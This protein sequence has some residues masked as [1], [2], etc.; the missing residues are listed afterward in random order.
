LHLKE[1]SYISSRRR[2]QVKKS[3]LAWPCTAESL[4][5]PRPEA[6]TQECLGADERVTDFSQLQKLPVTVVIPTLNEASQ[7]CEAVDAARWASEVVV[8]DGGSTDGTQDLARSAGARVLEVPRRTIAAQRNAG[9]VAAR[10]DW[11]LALDADERVTDD[12]RDELGAV[13]AAPQHAA[14]RIHFRN[15]YLG[16][17]LRHGSWGRDWHVRLFSH[18]R[19]FLERRVHE[20]L[21]P[22]D[23]VGSLSMELEHRPYRDL[24]HHFEK[25]IR[26]ARWGA[27]DL[28]ARGR[29]PSA[30]DVTGVPAWRFFREYVIFS[31]W[32]DGRPGLVVAALSACSALLK[33]AYLFALEWQTAGRPASF[34][35]AS[36]SVRKSGT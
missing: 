34:A 5:M 6:A 7:I 8:V 29:R 19:R 21:E 32:R 16:R 25:M 14:Y 1:R 35:A 33:Y 28:Y 10:N 23:D 17:Q 11:I 12:L 30:W 22:I 24:T 4:A 9:I 13:L 3:N 36:S 2:L 20:S 31:G 27:E 15:F 26:Y 18:E